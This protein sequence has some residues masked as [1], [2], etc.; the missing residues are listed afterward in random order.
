VLFPVTYCRPACVLYQK[1][2]LDPNKIKK[3]KA[4]KPREKI[5]YTCPI[6][7]RLSYIK[8]KCKYTIF[9]TA[10]CVTNVCRRLRNSAF[11]CDTNPFRVT[12]SKQAFRN[13][14]HYS[15]PPPYPRWIMQA[16]E[17]RLQGGR[18]GAFCTHHTATSHSS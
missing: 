14:L 7:F 2:V 8:T 18:M 10:L 4:G 11:G 1:F 16:W 13:S 17:H 15:F 3:K 6:I 5:R 9:S 12:G